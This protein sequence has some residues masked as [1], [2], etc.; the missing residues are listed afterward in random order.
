[1]VYDAEDIERIMGF[2]S[3]SVK[4]KVDELLRVDAAMYSNLGVSSRRTEQD[5]VRKNSRKIYSAIKKLDKDLGDLF[6]RAMDDK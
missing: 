3:W 6:L 2:T 5:S 4:R 1:M